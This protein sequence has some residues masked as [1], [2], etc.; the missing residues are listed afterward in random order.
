MSEFDL[1][2]GRNVA[3]EIDDARRFARSAIAIFLR[4]ATN[5][6]E[7]LPAIP[8]FKTADD[9]IV[10]SSN[11]PPG[12]VAGVESVTQIYDVSG[13]LLF[14]DFTA[15][16]VAGTELRVRT[17]AN[18]LLGAP[19]FSIGANAP[20]H[21]NEAVARASEAA[22]KGG[23]VP[24]ELPKGII[25]YSYPKLGLLCRDPSG[26]RSV[27]DL[28]DLSTQAVD[29]APEGAGDRE[30]ARAV[31][32][33]HAITPSKADIQLQRFQNFENALSESHIS[34][35]LESIDAGPAQKVVEGVKCIAQENRVWCAVATAKMI[36]DFYGFVHEQSEIAVT[37]STGPDGTPSDPNQIDGYK[38][39]SGS[40]LIA[41][42]DETATFAEAQSELNAGRPLKSGIPGHARVVVGWKNDPAGEDGGAWL[43]IFDPWQ[44]A[45]VWEKWGAVEMLNFIYV[46][47]SQTS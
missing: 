8:E 17:T 39:L 35:A 28:I 7:T 34:A 38:Q 42:Y 16:T 36:L 43:Y 21:I 3:V 45:K 22:R 18:K 14:R 31:P 33:L 23:L 25:C 37:M 12:G 46:R 29:N 20:L 4:A 2:D 5:G 6:L 47:Q 27:V 41:S 32:L 10:G 13:R 9:G 1:P 19:V 40:A 44:G 15:Q 26:R 24:A 11:D 30:L